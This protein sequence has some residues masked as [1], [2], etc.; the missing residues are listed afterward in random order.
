MLPDSQLESL[1]PDWL[2]DVKD[3]VG[4]LIERAKDAPSRAATLPVLELFRETLH[5]K[6]SRFLGDV[7]IYLNE[8]GDKT[9]PGLIISTVL[10]AITTA[11]RNHPDE[12]LIIIT[13]SMGGNILYDI[14]TYYVPELK[15]D[16]WVSVGGQVAQFEEMKLFKASDK[17]IGEPERVMDLEPRVG[18]WLN[19]Y[20]PA[21]SFSFKTE[22]VFR[23]VKDLVYLT[24]ANVL[25]SHSE[26]FGRVSFYWKMQECLEK[27]L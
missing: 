10:E 19:I 27:V 12:P 11:P 20:D 23:G 24:G 1:G 6:L 22:P 2:E 21:D 7:F 4:E 5:H 14:L 8:R 17:S 16:A 25:K 18:Y 13:H 15:V 3:R 26:Y 9:K